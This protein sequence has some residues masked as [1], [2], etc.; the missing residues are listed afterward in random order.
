MSDWSSFGKHIRLSVRGESHGAE[1]T[2][3]LENFPE[4]FR[5]DQAK[6]A[7]FMERRAPG[8]DLL[9]TSRKEPDAV[10]FT[11]GVGADSV[12]TGGTVEGR[13]AN[14][15]TRP[16][17]Y[18]S[19][20]TVP[21]PGHADFGQWI[22]FG[23]IPTGGGM[24][25][26]RLT[27]LLCAAGGICRQLLEERGISVNASIEQIHGKKTDFEGEISKARS[28]GDSVGGTIICETTGLQ[29]GLG[30]PLFDGVETELGAALFAIPAVNGVEFGNGFAA[31][32]LYGS[33]ND[34]PFYAENGT[35]KTRDNR[36][37]GLL[38]GR[39]SGMPL[40]FRI[41]LKPTPTVFKQ[42]NSVDLATMTDSPLKMKGRH[43][44][45]IVR[46]AVPVVEAVTS[47]A[48]ADIILADEAARPRICLT[49]TGSTIE[50]DLAQFNSQRY[51]T[52]IVELRADLLEESEREK[53]ALFPAMV[54]VPAILT[55]RRE[56][57]GGRY[58]G[59]ESVREAF[60]RRTLDEA[61]ANGRCF[62]F[63]D[64]EDD[65]RIAALVDSAARAG[66]KII[67]SLHDFSGPVTDIPERC[68]QLRG[69][70]GE[71]PKIAFKPND[72][73]DVERLFRETEDFTDIPHI[74]LAMGADGIAS[75]IL[76]AKTHSYLSFASVSGLAELGHLSPFELVRRYRFREYKADWTLTGVTGFPLMY[77]RSPELHN[78]AYAV[79]DKD[80]LM[81]PFRTES[82]EKALSFM[83]A[84]G[85]RGMA[86]TIPLKQSIMPLLDRI[87][88]E[89]AGIGAVNTVSLEGG[90]YVGYN[91]DAEGFSAAIT[92]FMEKTDFSSMK[93]AVL[94]AGGASKAIVYALRRLGAEVEVFHRRPLDAGFDLIVNA[95]PVDPVPEYT[96]SGSEALYDLRYSPE[97]TP[98]MERAAA[99]GCKTENG[100][101]MLVSQAAAQRR[102][103]LAIP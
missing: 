95:T 94:G 86:V 39:T 25:S 98:L 64:F 36:Q 15:D 96:F 61:A 34:D 81:I 7:A 73:S 57:D 85:L 2:F 32:E 77:T 62:A 47:L 82:A 23:R 14:K 90:L 59:P 58:A 33:E 38:G 99:A 1:L 65:F 10:E 83:K 101:S 26:G 74:T 31:T 43:D 49:L 11:A 4:G 102:I 60:F 54:P 103:W 87:S 75:R 37:G 19:E 48:L 46:R 76:A 91:T 52:D 84:L 45:C 53:A 79:K 78:L 44:P 67:R 6:L 5:I 89:A 20:R 29:P 28:E 3:R 71:I 8:R 13:I 21:R 80:A 18:G 50:E 92:R 16:G 63:A 70:S 40:V 100:F 55:F 93:V 12:T 35:V 69:A 9:S 68:R 42:V 51:F 22:R 30:G 97:T 24:N 88:P 41:S 27:A 72:I 56:C 17:D 66:T